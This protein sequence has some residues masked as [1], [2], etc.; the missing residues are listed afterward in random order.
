MNDPIFFGDRTLICWFK[1]YEFNIHWI[2]LWPN[3]K[4]QISAKAFVVIS[5][6]KEDSLAI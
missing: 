5:I 1:S 3:N 6:Q 2:G 4:H